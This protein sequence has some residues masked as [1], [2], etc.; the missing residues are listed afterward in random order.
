MRPPDF[1]ALGV[2]R[3]LGT[4][5]PVAICPLPPLGAPDSTEEPTFVLLLIVYIRLGS[6]VEVHL[7]EFY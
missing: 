3:P 5:G 7:I 1:E 4:C 6:I 2:M